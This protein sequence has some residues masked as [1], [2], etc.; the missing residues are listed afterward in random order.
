MTPFDKHR[1]HALAPLPPAAE[2]ETR[3]VL[4]KTIAARAA[5]A[6]LKAMSQLLPNQSV[7]MQTIGL[8]EA[9]LS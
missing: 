5:L 6:E 3:L 4:K 9:K 2:L 8:Q 7:L 1:P